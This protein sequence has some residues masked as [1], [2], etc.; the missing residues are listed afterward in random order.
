MRLKLP[1]SMAVA[2]CALLGACQSAYPEFDPQAY[3]TGLLS[4]SAGQFA[5][6]QRDT[7]VAADHYLAALAHNP[8]DD[9]LRSRAFELLVTNGRFEEA[10]AIDADLTPGRAAFGISRMLKVVDALLA[11]DY[12]AADTALDNA[13]GTGFDGLIKPIARAWIRAGEGDKKG[14]L[15]ALSAFDER[16][17][18]L[19]RFAD[20]HRA[21]V[22]AYLGDWQAAE[23]AYL[24]AIELTGS[25]S[26]RVILD[27]ASRLSQRGEWGKAVT[28]VRPLA[29]SNPGVMRLSATMQALENKRAL[30]VLSSSPAKGLSEALYRVSTEML[31]RTTAPTAVIYARLATA[32]NPDFDEAYYLIAEVLDAQD[33]PTDALRA[34]EAIGPDSLIWLPAQARKAG[35]LADLDARDEA[36]QLM[37]AVLAQRP[38][39]VQGHAAL[40]DLYREAE[41]FDEAA[42]AY[43]AA[44]SKTGETRESDWFL[45]YARGICYERTDRWAKAEADFLKALELRPDD[46]FVLN[47][48]GY[49]WIDRG[50]NYDRGREMIEKAV[51][52]R[53]NDGYITDSL[54]WAHY[55]AG[56]YEKA[57]EVLELAVALQPG[58][59]TINDHLGDAYWKVGRTIEARFKWRQVLDLDAEADLAERVA[60]KLDLGLTVVEAQ[61]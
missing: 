39:Y 14:A 25:A 46:P 35:L 20:E 21:M 51:A 40:G 16:P 47:Y 12:R 19:K 17:P 4:Y 45:Y 22:L 8:E 44:L 60:E 11:K 48:L 5:L 42:L 50:M 28:I 59:A 23:E 41:R 55:L 61:Q 31:N 49:S 10:R 37:Q 18:A 26:A 54:G 9:Y 38:D 30:E 58:D 57:V 43:D 7:N 52:A 36:I 53:P 27:Y 56:E 33:L 6:S 3:E 24:Q 29:A 32:L 34:Y 13:T 2:A 15:E 1:L